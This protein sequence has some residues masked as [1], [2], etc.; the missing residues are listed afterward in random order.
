MHQSIPGT[1]LHHFHVSGA[2]YRKQLLQPPQL[3]GPPVNSRKILG[4]RGP[5]YLN[6]TVFLYLGKMPLGVLGPTCVGGF[7]TLPP[8]SVLAWA[9]LGALTQ[10]GNVTFFSTYSPALMGSTHARNLTTRRNGFPIMCI[11]RLVGHLVAPYSYA[12]H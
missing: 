5:H 9:F 7:A 1:R 8:Q 10:L 3:R 11:V 2:P 6:P 12:T 4:P